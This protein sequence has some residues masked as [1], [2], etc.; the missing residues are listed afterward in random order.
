ML[1]FSLPTTATALADFPVALHDP[2]HVFL[3]VVTVGLRGMAM[4]GRASRPTFDII[5]L[6]GTYPV[7]HH[8]PGS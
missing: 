5:P 8:T 2:Q 7:P 4:T 6:A 3:T 1:V